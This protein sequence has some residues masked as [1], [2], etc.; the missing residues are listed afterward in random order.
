MHA[1]PAKQRVLKLSQ[2]YSSNYSRITDAII[3]V[4]G[5]SISDGT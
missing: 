4:V 1:I 2:Y 3:G 5:K